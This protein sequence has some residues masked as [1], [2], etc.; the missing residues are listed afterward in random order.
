MISI[1]KYICAI[2]YIYLRYTVSVMW[3]LSCRISNA[4]E[5]VMNTMVSLISF[6]NIGA[7]PGDSVG[8]IFYVN[9]ILKASAASSPRVKACYWAMAH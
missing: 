6:I 5:R 7:G 8:N 4:T 1:Y 2:I 9:T 3:R